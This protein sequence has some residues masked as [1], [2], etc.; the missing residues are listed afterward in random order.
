MNLQ[1]MRWTE[2]LAL[3][4]LA[5]VHLTI[6][7][8]WPGAA[9]DRTFA[10]AALR[11]AADLSQLAL[12]LAWA[13]LGP[14]AVRWRWPAA[15]LLILVW[16][17]APA[18]FSGVRNW[19]TAPSV[20]DIYGAEFLAVYAGALAALFLALRC[21]GVGVVHAAGGAS[22]GLRFRFSLRAMFLAIIVSAILVRGAQMMHRASIERP[23]LIERFAFAG[24]AATMA[25][26]A[27]F[28]LWAAL[29]PGRPYRRLLAL[30]VVAPLLAFI[31]PYLGGKE[32]FFAPLN[33]LNGAL[34]IVMTC[35][36]LV[37]RC[38]G[39]YLLLL[40]SG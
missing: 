26:V 36:L 18:S 30:G 35:S 1:L 32:F 38:C 40:K 33:Y 15:G 28:S 37:G 17:N 9:F 39:Y 19:Q 24:L 5:I 8:D 13:A 20:C 2:G 34:A 21:S 4:F 14:G 12:L 11:D 25:I 22:C 31:P 7:F 16:F 27:V 29:S 3:A 6:R 10:F 23:E